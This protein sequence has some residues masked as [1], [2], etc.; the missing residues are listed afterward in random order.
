MGIA[1]SL[2]TI[3]GF[4]GPYIVGAITNNNVS[5]PDEMH[6]EWR[7][8]SVCY[9][10]NDGSVASDIQYL[11]WHRGI[12]MCGVLRLVQRRGEALESSA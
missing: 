4:V 3:P 6:V 5:V 9:L 1:N 2:G 8:S 7:V 11:S 12:R 10:A